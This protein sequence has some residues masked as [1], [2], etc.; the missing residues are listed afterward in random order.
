MT[1][2][3]AST[4]RVVRVKYVIAEEKFHVLVLD[5]SAK[6]RRGISQER[7]FRL[8]HLNASV[9]SAHGRVRRAMDLPPDA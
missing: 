8:T 6:S 3:T 2:A 5:A 1:T 4:I 9:S 7:G